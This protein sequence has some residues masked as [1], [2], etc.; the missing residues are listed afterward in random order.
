MLL[1]SFRDPGYDA[2]MKC[3][4]HESAKAIAA[5]GGAH[6]LDQGPPSYGTRRLNAYRWIQI[7]NAQFLNTYSLGAFRGHTVNS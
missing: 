4:S 2:R 3:R 7:L 5:G 6:D 1:H